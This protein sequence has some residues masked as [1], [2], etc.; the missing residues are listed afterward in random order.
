MK[1][2]E[3]FLFKAADKFILST[4]SLKTKLKIKNIPSVTINGIYKAELPLNE[5][6]DDNKIHL[7]Y[8]G[9]FDPKKGG[10]Y[11]AIEAA[12]HLPEKYHLHVVGF[13][14][15]SQLHEVNQLIKKVD[16][17]SDSTITY[18]GLLK[19]KD[20]TIFLQKCH[21]GLSTQNPESKYNDTSFPSK[22]LSYL[23]NGI[24]VVTVRIRV[25]EKS[26]VGNIVI[27]FDEPLP[28]KIA[29]AI[30]SVNLNEKYDSR[31]LLNNLDEKFK[32][33]IN[34]LLEMNYAKKS[35]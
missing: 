6:F 25:V 3:L 4:D 29:E 17:I 31:E 34:E 12:G 19:G 22:I 35:V 27:Y 7:V 2:N 10:V 8:A 15:E 20:F 18:D 32:T 23:A 24:R 1:K 28:E 26:T 14:S 5:R 30:K 33:E 13:G 21:I 16:S 11:T 9:T